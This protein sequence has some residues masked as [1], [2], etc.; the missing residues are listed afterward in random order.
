MT[1][2]LKSV[3]AAVSLTRSTSPAYSASTLD[4]RHR[5]TGS[6]GSLPLPLERVPPHRFD[7]V[8]AVLGRVVGAAVAEAG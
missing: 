3:G 7:P 6:K 1:Q 5:N 4:A 8:A 2:Y